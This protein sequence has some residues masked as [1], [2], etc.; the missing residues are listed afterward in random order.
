[1]PTTYVYC[2]TDVD[3]PVAL[4]LS[5]L[6][7]NLMGAKLSTNSLPAKAENTQIMEVFRMIDRGIYVLDTAFSIEGVYIAS[8]QLM[9]SGHSF[10]SSI[11]WRWRTAKAEIGTWRTDFTAHSTAIVA[12]DKQYT[13]TLTGISSVGYAD[14]NI[15]LT[16]H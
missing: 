14:L 1:M 2:A 11:W 3:A 13:L 15:S 5:P 12:R 9:L 10:G 7:P 4:A 16:D 6:G 8:A